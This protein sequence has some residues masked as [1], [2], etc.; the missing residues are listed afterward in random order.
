MPAE[1]KFAVN[2]DGLIF[3]RAGASE[4]DYIKITDEGN[5][6]IGTMTPNTKL[7]VELTNEPNE[8]K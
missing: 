8:I 6:G 2:G 4:Y 1:I 3:S 7:A 5:F